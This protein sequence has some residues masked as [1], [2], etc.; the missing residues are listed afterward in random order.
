M[1]LTTSD[2]TEGCLE[3]DY[4]MINGTWTGSWYTETPCPTRFLSPKDL[5]VA[6]GD[7]EEGVVVEL[8]LLQPV[9]ELPD[10]EVGGHWIW[11][12]RISSK[13]VASWH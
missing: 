10:V 8:H 3:F 12:I 7:D 11:K 5:A 13:Q 2:L 1:L 6:R 9:N 4:L